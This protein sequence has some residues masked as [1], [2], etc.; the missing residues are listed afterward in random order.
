VKINIIKN[1]TINKVIIKQI[2]FY[3]GLICLDEY[4]YLLYLSKMN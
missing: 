4:F 2:H 3:D 1:I